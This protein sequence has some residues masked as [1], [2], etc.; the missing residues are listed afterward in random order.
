MTTL[1][2]GGVLAV[3]SDEDAKLV[4]GLRFIGAR[5]YEGERDRYWEPAMTNVDIDM[6]GV[7]PNNFCLGEA[8]CALGSAGLKRLDKTNDTL[9]AQAHKIKAALADVPEI[10]FARIPPGYRHV[11]HQFVMHFDGSALGK[12]R[13]DLMDILANQDR[14][15]VIVQYYPLYRYPLFQKLGAGGHNCPILES[16]WDNTFS[17]PWWCGMLDETIDYL[18]SALTAAIVSF[19][20][21]S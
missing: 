8:Q 17:F 12:R 6:E 13:N 19:R 4:P 18:T 5:P 16:W 21:D 20:S 14:I 1:G 10:S 7:W 3:Q 2:E 15:R 9:I 11:F